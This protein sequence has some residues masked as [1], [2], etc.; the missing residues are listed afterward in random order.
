MGKNIATKLPNGHKVYNL[1]VFKIALKY[2]KVFQ[3]KAL[4]NLPKLVFLF[5]N[6][7]SGNPAPF[8]VSVDAFSV[9]VR[10]TGNVLENDQIRP[11]N[12]PIFSYKGKT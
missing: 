12:H 3:F 8:C 7:P 5:E 9:G 2:T 6:I 1:A 4:Q 11:K 10:V